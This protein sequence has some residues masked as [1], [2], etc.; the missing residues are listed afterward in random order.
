MDNFAAIDFETAN[1]ERT[2]ICSVGVVIVRNGEIADRFYSLVHP[3]PDYYLY[4]NTRIHG[5]TQEDTAHAPVFSEVW[6][7]VAPKIEGLPLVAHNKA[8]DERCL[9]AVFRTYCM[10]YPDYDFYCTYQASRK[11]KGLRN[12]QLHTVAGF[13]GFELENHH[14]ALADAEACAWI[15]RQI[16]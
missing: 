16:L 9:K 5:L 4:W 7:Q 8:F 13:F 1:N 14:H 3:E 6:K 10:D 12:H 11:L 2:S 15:A